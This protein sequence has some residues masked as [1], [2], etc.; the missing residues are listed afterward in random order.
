MRE[1]KFR[2]KDKTT[3]NWYY[4]SSC[5]K[6]RKGADVPL[7][8]FWLWFEM[9]VLDPK[10]VGQWTGRKDK[11]GKEIYEGDIVK[12]SDSLAHSDWTKLQKT[13]YTRV[14]DD[15]REV[16]WLNSPAISDIEVIGNIYENPGLLEEEK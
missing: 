10:T 4:G 6:E 16:Q 9:G 7:S 2:A 13:E 1:I 15:I 3:G 11:N 12:Y 5:V 8:I 14:I